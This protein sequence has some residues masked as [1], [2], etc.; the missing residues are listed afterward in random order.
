VTP[1][2][3]YERALRNGAGPKSVQEQLGHSRVSITLDVYTHGRRR[4][5]DLLDDPAPK[6]AQNAPDPQAAGAP[7]AD[8]AGLR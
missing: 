6:C 1:A 7:M 3:R 8:A 4:V 5:V 2:S